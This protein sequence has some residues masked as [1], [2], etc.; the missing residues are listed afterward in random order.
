MRKLLFIV[1]IVFATAPTLRADEYQNGI[2]WK[3][4][5]KVTPGKTDSAAPSDAVVLF[6]GKNLDAWHG[7]DKWIVKD[8]VATVRGTDIVSKQEFGD[9]QLH[10]EWSAPNPPT[11]K[12]QGCGNS[13]VFLMGRFEM[14]VLDSYTTKTYHDGQAGA[15]YKQ[16]PPMVNATR[17]PGEW[18]SYDIFWTAPIFEEDGTLKTPAYITATHNGV[19]IVNHYEIKGETFYHIPPNYKNV[20]S[21]KGPIKLQNHGNPIRYRNIWVRETKPAAGKQVREPYI[22]NHQTGED[23]V[24]K[25]KSE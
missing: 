20:R 10:V 2:E 11:G 8:G 9:C 14:Q 24:V 7:G 21:S 23:R 18:N 12:G 25:T 4:P 1:A 19:L 17:A 3:E 22:H 13:G 5:A 16:M 15:I 6:D